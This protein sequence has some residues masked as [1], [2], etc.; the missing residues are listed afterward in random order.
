MFD[1]YGYESF[2][3]RYLVKKLLLLLFV[4]RIFKIGKR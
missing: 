3:D 2:Y 4:I 1:Y